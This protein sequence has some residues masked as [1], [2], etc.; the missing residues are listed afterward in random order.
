M[1]F[2]SNSGVN[3]SSL[4]SESAVLVVGHSI[5]GELGGGVGRFFDR[6]ASLA[7]LGVIDTVAAVAVAVRV[8]VA[9]SVNIRFGSSASVVILC[10]NGGDES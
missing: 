10:S 1:I 7:G 9:V 4:G 8:H 2:E 3:G 6:G 5:Q